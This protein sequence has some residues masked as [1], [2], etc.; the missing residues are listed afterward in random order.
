[1]WSQEYGDKDFYLLDSLDLSTI[2]AYDKAIIDSS[3]L[4]YHNTLE[5][6]VQLEM[7]EYIV[8]N[9]WDP[10][11]WPRYNNFLID[12][13]KSKLV[14]NKSD[15]EETM[16]MHYLAGAI[17]NKGFLHDQRGEFMDALD[18]Y[19]QSLQL[20]EKIDDKEGIG[21]SFNN[22]GV[23]YS[24]IGD[25][26][27]AFEYHELSLKTKLEIKDMHGV[28]M[29]YN[30]IGTLYENRNQQFIALEYYERSLEIYEDLDDP[31][32][33]A[34]SYDNI[35]NIYFMEEVYGKALHYYLQS[36]K[37]WQNLEIESGI[38]GSYNSLA[39]CHLEMGSTE[40]AIKYGMDSYKLAKEIGFPV[41]IENSSKTLMTIYKRVGDFEMALKYS[42]E[43]IAIRERIR[44]SDNSRGALK[45]SMQY[46]YQKMALRDSLEHEKQK[47]I[48]DVE[49]ARQKTQSYALYAGIGLLSILF[50]VGYRSYQR[51]KKDNHEINEQKAEIENQ[52]VALAKTH[53]EI[54]DSISYAKR[55]QEA[56]LP[57]HESFKKYLPDAFIY[58]RPK[59]VV[60]GDFYWLVEKGDYL[61]VA[62]ADCTGHGV[63]GAMVSVICSN[64]LNRGR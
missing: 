17:S 36:L 28:A 57:S 19:H 10:M 26:I 55:I 45:K 47:E 20:Y 15:K 7:L 1:M 3:L 52:H 51:K 62:A 49:I 22:L 31:R 27:K 43:Y 37:I 12:L 14:F 48:R 4:I 18:Y 9:C 33:I 30:N 29:S 21:T 39:R 34:I 41:N 56:I 6:S 23:L 60:S 53:K 54:S 5:D 24:M 25:T 8:D 64:A 44:S 2:S 11:V 46:E 13:I 40:M 32:G 38:S 59:D 61:F 63:P 35:G 42:E 50:V 16:Y 58:Y